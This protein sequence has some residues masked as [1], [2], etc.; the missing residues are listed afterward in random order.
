M[1]AIDLSAGCLLTRLLVV[2]VVVSF[3]FL[4]VINTLK[5]ANYNALTLY[6][7]TLMGI[8]QQLAGK[9]QQLYA[10]SRSVSVKQC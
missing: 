1:L 2:Q 4:L 10:V 7:S 6:S 3:L 9:G 8:L 5:E